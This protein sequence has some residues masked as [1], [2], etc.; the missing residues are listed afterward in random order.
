MGR[1]KKVKGQRRGSGGSSGWF[2]PGAVTVALCAVVATV[3]LGGARQSAPPSRDTRRGSWGAAQRTARCTIDR[4]EGLSRE[5]FLAEYDGR[6]PVVLVGEAKGW[7][8][9]N[10]VPSPTQAPSCRLRPPHPPRLLR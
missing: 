5:D 1:K 6:K 7:P 4:R 10:L 3:F 9:A 8:A 2:V